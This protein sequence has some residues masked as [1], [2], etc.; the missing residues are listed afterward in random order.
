MR[1][2]PIGR[3]EESSSIYTHVKDAIEN[4][5]HG[6]LY[7]SGMPGCGKTLTCSGVVSAIQERYKDIWVIEV[8]CGTLS[9]PNEVFLAVHKKIAPHVN[10]S[11]ARVLEEVLRQQKYTV[12]LVDEIDMLL[13]KGQAVLYG[14]LE[15]PSQCKNVYLIT[16][17]NTYNLPDKKLLSKVR[18]RLGWNRMNFPMYKNTDIISILSEAKAF[19]PFTQDG[20]EYCARKISSLNGDIRK[21]MLIQK[22]AVEQAKKANIERVGIAEVDAAVKYVFHSMQGSFIRSLSDYQKIILHIVA[23]KGYSFPNNLYG[24]FRRILAA[25]ELH[26]VPF[27]EFEALL[28]KM[29]S[30]GI[31]KGRINSLAV[32][33][34]YIPEEL[35]MI[36]NA[37]DADDFDIVTHIPSE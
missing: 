19:L 29:T 32:E 12:L 14:L 24:D 31:L 2:A 17:S 4:R 25:K 26:Q 10:S 33:T 3:E 21:A 11:S 6:I 9:S 37:A 15:I 20:L 18:S 27:K 35:E 23:Q 7:V 1:A 13:N 30:M 5:E 36:M 16:I 34:E 28:C 22:Y 8:N